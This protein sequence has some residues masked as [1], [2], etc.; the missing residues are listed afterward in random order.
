[1][2]K[3]LFY[4]LLSVVAV[5]L[6][7]CGY[8][9]EAKKVT[10]DF[11]SAIK[12]DKEDK[13]IE[14]YPEVGNLQNYYKS[15]T[16]IVKEVTELEEKKYSVSVTNKFTNGFGK[17]SESQITIY[18]KPKNEE[19]PSDGYIIYDS[20]GL[21]DLSDEL[22]YK[23]AKRK[24]YVKGDSITD[25]Q[26]AK[27][28]KEASTELMQLTLKFNAYLLENVKIS[29]WSW[30]SSDYS[31]SASGSGVVK[32]N[33][34]YSIPNLK[35]IVTYKRNGEEISQDDGSVSY[36]EVCPYG[37][38]SFSFYTSYVGNA[39][40]AS[41]RLDFD[42]EFMIETVANGEFDDAE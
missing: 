9:N 38:K 30:E 24:G 16:I 12:N 4:M 42:S 41:I 34:K 22:I 26:I 6:V 2:I 8:K 17:S 31:Y 1:M 37:M 25:Q 23:F 10:Q 19:K 14:L 33:T 15:D 7:S 5:G 11:F 40:K 39:N 35:Y 28:V 18:T 3:I 29:D 36:D 27:N 21:C 13:M 20:K 32:N